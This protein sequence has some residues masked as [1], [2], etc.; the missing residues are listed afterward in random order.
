MIGCQ[1][2]EK[3][4]SG[5]SSLSDGTVQLVDLIGSGIPGAS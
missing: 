2:S 4:R 3:K 5:D 1:R